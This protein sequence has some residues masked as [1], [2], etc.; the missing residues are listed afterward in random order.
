MDS[1]D[2]ISPSG[3]LVRTAKGNHAFSPAPLPP[4]LQ[5][6]PDI[7]M[8]LSQADTALAELSATGRYLPN[9]H[10]LIAPYVRRE[11]VLS[12]RIEGTQTNLSDLFLDEVEED[13]REKDADVV[14]V[15]NYVHALEHGIALLNDLPLSL[16]LVRHLHHDLMQ[17]VRGANKTPGEFRTGQNIVGAKGQDEITASYVPPPVEEMNAALA[18]WEQYINEDASSPTLIQCA[19][20]HVQ[21]ES[22]HPFWDGNGRIGRLL[23]TIFLI[24]KG[25]LSQPLLY[26]SA[27]IEEHRQDY[28]D[29]LQRTR[30]RSE[31]NNWIRFFLTGIIEIASDSAQQASALIQLREDYR[32][33]MKHKAKALMLIDYLLTNPYVTVARARKILDVS[34]PTAQSAI[35]A[36][37]DAGILAEQTGRS[38]GRVYVAKPIL[39]IID[40]KPKP[41]NVSEQLTPKAQTNSA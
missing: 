7:V 5:F 18:T 36:L 23:I 17:G 10:L 30:T 32:E 37:A 13:A 39:D 29:L 40:A 33:K 26:L 19:L 1:K 9:P 16:R 41:A 6:D 12:S 11:A 27:F 34:Q 38:W 20:Q 28:Y 24:N 14:E 31:W 22:I 3:S 8:L 15:R 35:T 2:F 21:F 25:R 4:N